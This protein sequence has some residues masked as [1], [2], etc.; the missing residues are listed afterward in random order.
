[1]TSPILLQGAPPGPGFTLTMEDTFP[2]TTLNTANWNY[3]T[4]GILQGY[5]TAANVVVSNGLSIYGLAKTNVVGTNTYNFTCGGIISK[6]SFGYGYYEIQA[7]LSPASLPGWHQSFWEAGGIEVDGFEIPSYL[8]SQVDFNFIYWWTTRYVSGM[9]NTGIRGT[10]TFPAGQDSS[11]TNHIYGWEY[12]PTGVTY[13]VDGVAAIS[14]TEAGPLAAVPVYITSLADNEAGAGIVA[15]SVMQVS[16]F[17][18]YSNTYGDAKPAGTLVDITSASLT[19]SWATDSYAF[20]YNGLNNTRTS[21]NNGNTVKWTP[22]LASAGSCEVLIWNPSFYQDLTNPV[23]ADARSAHYLVTAANGTNLPAPVDQF[24]AGQQWVS[25]GTFAFNAGTSG[26]VGLIVTNSVTNGI[27][28]AG[29][30]VFRPITNAPAAPAN[31]RAVPGY[32]RIGLTW[33]VPMG[34]SSINVKRAT[35]SGGPYTTITNVSGFGFTDTV[36]SNGSAY[37]YVVSA[38]NTFGEGANSAEIAAIPPAT[39]AYYDFSTGTNGWIVV[40]GIWNWF[41]SATSPSGYV[42]EETSTNEALAHIA[43]QNWSNYT[44]LASVRMID[45]GAAGGVVGRFVDSSDYYLLRIVEGPSGTIDL[46]KQIGGVWTYVASSAFPSETNTWY[47]VALVMNGTNLTGWINGNQYISATDSDLASGTI[48]MRTYYGSIDF[49]QVGAAPLTIAPSVPTAVA[50][51]GTNAAVLLSW[52]MSIGAN[53]YTVKRATNSGGPYINI[54]YPAT[55]NYADTNLVNGTNYYYVMTASTSGGESGYSIEVSATP[56]TPPPQPPIVASISNQVI[57]AGVTLSLTVVASDPN[58]P[59]LPLNWSLLSGP[60]GASL[61]T[62]NGVT[63]WRPSVTQAGTSNLFQVVVSKN[64][65]SVPPSFTLWPVVDTYAES[66][67]TAGMNFGTAT[68]LDVKLYN[69]TTNYTRNAF[70]RF[71]LTGVT[72]SITNSTLELMPVATS[73]PGTHGISM[74]TNDS[75][76]ELSLTWNSQPAAGPSFA[77]WIPQVGVPLR[78]PVTAPAQAALTTDRLLS[79]QVNALTATSDGLVSYGSRESVLVTNRPVL[80]INSTMLS[81]TQTFMVTV[82]PL[83]RPALTPTLLANGS[84]VLTANGQYGPDLTLQVSTNLTTWN[85]LLTTNSPSFPFICTDTNTTGFASRFY[86]LLLGP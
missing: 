3:R 47:D 85:T 56:V 37:F 58:T 86:R 74:V 20:N 50:A 52:Q 18:Y 40:D 79:F 82:S 41:S 38:V 8:P 53:Y 6:Q 26:N 13:Y 28:R 43:A 67:T 63:T 22:N 17:R 69:A 78:L 55:T 30:V 42:Y 59:S 25:L 80:T 19:G 29:A 48:G 83:A 35:V 62:S 51:M 75:W 2:G 14:S 65:T 34:W 71:D 31:L 16:Y 54:S 46:M 36:A 76:G 72:G 11:Q 60:I 57:N 73:V 15:P 10:Y 27:Y 49:I 21:T 5:N 84:I 39:M 12:T 9:N 44:A 77:T 64:G 1:M 7:K 32:G 4:G 61:N 68:N 23:I 45:T 70:L 24:Y 66:G 81:T 33:I